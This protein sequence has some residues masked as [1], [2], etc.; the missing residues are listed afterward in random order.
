MSDLEV[1]GVPKTV[2][3][4]LRDLLNEDGALTADAVLDDARDADSPL[5]GFFEWDDTEAAQRYR[6][7]QARQLIA[8]VKVQ[9]ITSDDTEPVRVRAYVSRREIGKAGEDLPAGSYVP[10]EAVAGATDA[11]ASLLRGMRRDIARLRRRYT[12]FELL[13]K[14]EL[15]ALDLEQLELT[16]S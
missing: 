12:G 7:A 2:A 10:I 13:L 15:A 16:E 14:Q 8:R 4:R 3:R 5:H 1:A 11:E 6:I 9:I